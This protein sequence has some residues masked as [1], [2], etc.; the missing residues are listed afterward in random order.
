MKRILIIDDDE[1]W[2][3]MLTRALR[4]AGCEVF[5]TSSGVDGVAS[6]L[7]NRPHIILSDLAMP[8]GNG[9]YVVK[10]VRANSSMRGIEL[11]AVTGSNLIESETEAVAVGFDRMILK[12]SDLNNIV[13]LIL[14][15]DP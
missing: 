14:E 10:C 11:I 15:G 8:N 12:S 9:Y 3:E 2:V 1:A 4:R 7:R 13:K 5:S 6:A